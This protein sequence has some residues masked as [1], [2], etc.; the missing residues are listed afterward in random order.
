MKKIML[1]SSLFFLAQGAAFL[2]AHSVMASGGSVLD[3]IHAAGEPLQ[4]QEIETAYQL[5]VKTVS[6]IETYQ[7]GT[8]KVLARKDSITRFRCSVCHSDKKVL[9]NDG[10][11]FTHGDIEINHGRGADRLACIECHD[12]K[13]RDFLSDAQGEQIDFDHS[14]Q[15]C[16]QCHFRQ[17]RDWLGGA[18]GKRDTY[19]AG[20]RVV[21][22]C[23]SCHSP[24]SPAFEKK[25]P[26]T[27]SLPLDK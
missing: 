8:F 18:H 14:Y 10:V 15:L 25:M 22:N 27:Y 20:E 26:V 1:C 11:L 7:G 9:V 4:Q 6:A 21:W 19:W 12:V 24:H 2:S 13:N 16:G 17:K 3:R 5:P 23:T